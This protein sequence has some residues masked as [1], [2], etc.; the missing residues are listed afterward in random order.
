IMNVCGQQS[1]RAKSRTKTSSN[2]CKRPSSPT[3]KNFPHQ[4]S[5]LRITVNGYATEA[6][7]HSSCE[8]FGL[9][10]WGRRLGKNETLLPGDI[11][12]FEYASFKPKNGKAFTLVHHTAII[13]E[14]QDADTFKVLHQ[15]IGNANIKKTMTEASF[16][17]STLNSGAVVF[18]RPT[19]AE[20]ILQV[21]PTPFRK[22]PALPVKNGKGHIDLKRT[23]DPDL[24]SV[25]G[26]WGVWNNAICSHKDKFL[27]LQIPV[28]VPESYVIRATIKRTWGNDAYGMVLVVGGHQYLLALDA[29]GGTKSG[30]D[31]VA[32]KKLRS[33]VTTREIKNVLPLEKSMDVIVKVTPTTV[34]IDVDGQEL[35]DWSGDPADF[36]LQEPWRVPNTSWLHLGTYLSVFDTQH[37]TLEIVD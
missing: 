21:D 11:V 4:A 13:H 24:D 16:S 27:K 30:L 1:R 23:I 14:I 32:G 28:D 29:Y 5:S 7:K 36:S 20:N 12:Q 35:V 8:R 22:G 37:L 10:D 15:N 25:H 31:M 34:H 3:C 18:F 33:N 6:L 26:I 9:Y 2:S 17:M 19:L